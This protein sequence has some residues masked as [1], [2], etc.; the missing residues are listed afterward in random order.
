[1][2]KINKTLAIAAIAV[3]STFAAQSAK[4]QDT[5]DASETTE[6]VEDAGFSIEADN[7]LGA[8]SDK[9]FFS[10]LKYRRKILRDPTMKILMPV[11]NKMYNQNKNISVGEII[12]RL[13]TQGYSTYL[14]GEIPEM[15][16]QYREGILPFRTGFIGV[17]TSIFD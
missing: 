6:I 11:I 1:M 14:N 16:K 4:A 13:S 12:Q 9:G 17:V 2:N 10:A 5:F 3:A 15:I 8:S 7:E